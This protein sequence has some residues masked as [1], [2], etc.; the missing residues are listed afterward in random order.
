MVW[1]DFVFTWRER[2]RVEGPLFEVFEARDVVPTLELLLFFTTVVTAAGLPVI[3]V[4]PSLVP[5][6]TTGLRDTVF[7][8]IVVNFWFELEF[9]FVTR[10]WFVAD[11]IGHKLL[12]G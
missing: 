3:T 10:E 4:Y 2:V 1:F 12:F 5:I 9:R 7:F 6:D 8:W 11:C